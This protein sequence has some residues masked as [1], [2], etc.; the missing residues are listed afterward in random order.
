M[1]NGAPNSDAA[2]FEGSVANMPG[3][4]TKSL[5]LP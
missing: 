5:C 3:P 1:R 4:M 2:R